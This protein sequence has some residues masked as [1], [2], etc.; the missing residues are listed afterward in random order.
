MYG[1]DEL[2]IRSR[3]NV[4]ENAEVFTPTVMVDQM[5]DLIPDAAWNDP[6]FC[7]LEPTCGNGQFLVR[8]L[9]KRLVH[10]INVLTALNTLIGMDISELNILDSHKR[11]YEIV[12]NWMHQN[13]YVPQSK[14]W[15]VLAMQAIAIVRN[16]IF[17]VKDSLSYMEN[18]LKKKKFFAIDPTGNNQFLSLKEQNEKLEIIKEAMKNGFKKKVETKTLEPFFRKE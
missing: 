4:K 11:L 8:I 9:E 17:K 18:D 10:G 1:T 16:N 13:N 14:E 12:C 6:E 7:F 2:D 5:N 15:N 3:E